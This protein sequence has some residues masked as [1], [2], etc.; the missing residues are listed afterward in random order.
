MKKSIEGSTK[1]KSIIIIVVLLLVLLGG[2]IYYLNS[3]K[4][5]NFIELEKKLPENQV[6]AIASITKV[7]E[8][9][10]VVLLGKT[11]SNGY[12]YTYVFSAKRKKYMGN[13]F[14]KELKYQVN[15]TATIVYL[16]KNPSVN[17]FKLKD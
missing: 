13:A 7:V 17:S 2:I 9:S 6:E 1:K 10:K 16:P 5:V 11:Y 8:K 14:L 15:D 4:T 3:T 12:L